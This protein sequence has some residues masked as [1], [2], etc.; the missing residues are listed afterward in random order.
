MAGY[1]GTPLV[2]KLGI[3]A[4]HQV[5][6]P[7][8]PAD[9]ATTLG[10]LPQGVQIKHQ[11]RGPLDLIVSFCPD[12]ATLARSFA[13]HRDALVP[14]GSLWVAWPKASS[15]LQ[16]DLDRAGVFEIGHGGGLV[17]VKVA[18]IDD[19]WSGLK[20]VRRTEDR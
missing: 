1:S 15:G 9:F 2:R 17:D 11:A 19:T 5:A 12:R 13:R 16:T 7:R 8:A 4:G 20:F 18:A 14:D 10:T 6:F 3:K